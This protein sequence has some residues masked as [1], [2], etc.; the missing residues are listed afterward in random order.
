MRKGTAE[1]LMKINQEKKRLENESHIGKLTLEYKQLE[2]SMLQPLR[3]KL[4]ETS[5]KLEECE[6]KAADLERRKE[7]YKKMFFDLKKNEDKSK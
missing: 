3:T 1:Q 6:K 5:K 4:S 7:E 2:D